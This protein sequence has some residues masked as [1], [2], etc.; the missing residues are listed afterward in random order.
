M[1]NLSGLTHVGF[2]QPALGSN[3]QWNG[4]G[5]D[6]HSKAGLCE[7]LF[8]RLKREREPAGEKYLEAI[9]LTN[10][11]YLKHTKNSQKSTEKQTIQFK[12]DQKT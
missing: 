1:T 12:N 3:R 5:Q 9:Y 7:R 11:I 2:H 10:A 6:T 8:E 4:Y